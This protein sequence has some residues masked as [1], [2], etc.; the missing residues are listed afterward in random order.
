MSRAGGSPR[1]TAR[2]PAMN[3]LM[4]AFAF[5]LPYHVLRTAAAAGL[6]VHVLGGAPSKGLRRSHFCHRYRDTRSAG[7]PELLLAEIAELAERWAIDVVFPA[8][9]VST[10]LLA[11]LAGRLPVRST[12]LPGLATFDLLNDKWRFTRFCLENDVRA[13]QAWLFET[14]G[15]LLRAIDRGAIALP[16]TVKP[17]NRSGGFGVCH[18][19]ERRELRL[20]ESLDYRPILVQRHIL[21]ETI[22]FSAICEQ[23]RVVAHATQRRD[24]VRFGLFHNADLFA[25]VSRLVALTN[26]T[27]PANFDAVLSREDGLSYIVECNPR[28]WYTISLSMI[29]GLNFFDPALTP[30]AAFA[31]ATTAGDREFRLSLRQILARPWQASRLDWRFVRYCLADPVAFLLQRVRPYDDSA[32]A[33]PAGQTRIL[34]AP[35][36]AAS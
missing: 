18:L 30:S 25:N 32:V 6:R 5:A 10:R 15:D 29:A 31:Q 9:D 28:F 23:G 14:V 20:I 12:P 34:L 7:D 27:G 2:P 24:A 13:P 22:G 19:R 36:L 4:I 33:V 17:T 21:G 8:D 26:Y 1:I 3:G 11:I 35:Q 16:I